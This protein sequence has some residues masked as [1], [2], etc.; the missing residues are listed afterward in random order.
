MEHGPVPS[1]SLNEMNYALEQ[2]PEIREEEPALLKVLYTTRD[3]YPAFVLKDE[4]LFDPDVFSTSDLEVLDEV[5]QI[6]GEKSAWQLRRES[7]N[8]R[9]WVFA[10]H[11]R[12]P[13]SSFPIYFES[14]FD[15]DNRQ[16]LEMV[17]E[18][19]R[20]KEEL[21]VAMLKAA[22]LKTVA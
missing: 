21:E 10:D 4:K 20:E 3:R 5:I 14:L 22:S 6:H 16:M 1:N 11:F 18:D 8:E 17:L 13:G 9:A 7:H 15:E 2:D 12:A 19:Q